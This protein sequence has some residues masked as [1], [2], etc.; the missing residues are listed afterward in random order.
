MQGK[1]LVGERIELGRSLDLVKLLLFAGRLGQGDFR[2]L[3]AIALALADAG[4]LLLR[5]L[6]AGIDFRGVKELRKRALHV[7]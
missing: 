7:A 6:I 3:R 5:G 2:H 4:D 1:R